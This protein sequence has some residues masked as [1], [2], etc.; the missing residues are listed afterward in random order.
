MIYII[1]VTFNPIKD[2]YL[3][4]FLKCLANQ[5]E[6]FKAVIIDNDSKDGSVEQLKRIDDPRI[7]LVLNPINVGFAAACNQ[8]LRY[9]LR[10]GADYIVFLNNDT[11]FDSDFLEL[12]SISMDNSGADALSPLISFYPSKNRVWYSGGRFRVLAGYTPIH[13]NYRGL[14]NGA[15]IDSRFVDFASGCCLIVRRK[16]IEEIG[17]FDENYFVYWEDA[18]FCYRMI[19]S[20]YRIYFSNTP[21]LYHIGSAST[22]GSNSEFSIYQYNK[23]HVIFLRK[24]FGMPMTFLAFFY[25]LPK[26]FVKLLLRRIDFSD[27]KIQVKALWDGMSLN[28]SELFSH[29]PTH[30]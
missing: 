2:G 10:D 28:R 1:T 12:L 8:G 16:L 25:I 6:E 15:K 29:T 21:T 23:N 30:F 11:I 4:S 5:T 20:G 13:E 24:H 17:G 9:A 19:K 18:D 27:C 7:V 14:L 3:E 22:G 26:M